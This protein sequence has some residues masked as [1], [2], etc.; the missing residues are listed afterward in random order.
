MSEEQSTTLPFYVENI[1]D[2]PEAAK[3][4]YKQD[5][6]GAYSLNVDG[7][8]SKRKLQE[9]RDNNRKLSS[10][11]QEIESKYRHV[12]LDEYKNL[13]EK[14]ETETTK[15]FVPETDIDKQV[16][17]R[18]RKMQEDFEATEN[19]YKSTISNQQK[20]LSELLINNEVSRSSTE[21]N[22]LPS[23]LDDILNRVSAKFSVNDEGNVVATDAKGEIEFNKKGDPLSIAD[24]IKTL[25]ESAPHLFHTSTGAGTRGNVSNVVPQT[26]KAMTAREMIASGFAKR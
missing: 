11:L 23:A 18:V 5:D 12:D 15:G 3:G 2:V 7:V 8:V 9:F 4:F 22:A 16:S 6:E 21:A 14:I 19:T 20:R 25:K 1:D 26:Q 17:S 10:Q 13:K 24:Y